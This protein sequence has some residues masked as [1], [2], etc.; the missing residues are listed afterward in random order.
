[1]GPLKVVTDLL[2]PPRCLGCGALGSF[3]CLSCLAAT[4]RIDDPICPA[5]SLTIDPARPECRCR[6]HDLLYVRAAS[7]YD[8]PLRIAIHRFKY[9]G[10]KAAARDL[11]VV[12][13]RAMEPFAAMNPVVMPVPLHPRRQRQRG[14]NQAAL[15]ARVAGAGREM[16]VLESALRRIKA[17]PSQVGMSA[18]ERVQNL[19]GAFSADPRICARKDVLLVDDVCTTGAT[20]RAAAEALRRSGASRMIQTA[21]PRDSVRT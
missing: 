5:C 8:N 17:T 6:R 1:M 16:T 3:F 12:L 14:Y 20:L 18:E 19:Q 11:G 15:L 7:T 10:R 4:P 21:P 2:F 9:G 13:D